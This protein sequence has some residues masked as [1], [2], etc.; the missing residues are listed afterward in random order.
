MNRDKVGH[1]AGAVEASGDPTEALK[2]HCPLGTSQLRMWVPDH[3]IASVCT[4][5][6]WR[7]VPPRETLLPQAREAPGENLSLSP[8][9]EGC[10]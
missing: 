6:P 7:G 8:K 9:N 1:A 10:V 2:Q 5:R 3:S 4:G